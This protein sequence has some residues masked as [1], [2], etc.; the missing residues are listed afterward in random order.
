M[1]ANLLE[2]K[3]LLIQEQNK[4]T[5]QIS[6][7]PDIEQQYIN[8]LRD[9]EINSS[10]IDMLQ[11]RIL[12]F[13]IIEASTLSDINIIDRAYIHAQISPNPIYSLTLSLLIFGLIAVLISIY[14][15]IYVFSFN[16][17]SQLNEYVPNAK[18]LGVFP[19]FKSS[20][21]FEDIANSVVTSI[22]LRKEDNKASKIVVT[23]PLKAVGKTT[24]CN[25][26]AKQLVDHNKKVVVIDCDWRQG[27]MH[28]LYNKNRVDFE[29]LSENFD[30]EEFKIEENLYFLPRPKKVKR[31]S[32]GFFDSETF[33][34]IIEQLADKFDFVLI[35]S[36][37]S[38]SLSDS[39]VLSR[40][41]DF[42][43]GVCRHRV[44]KKYELRQFIDYFDSMGFENTYILY[45][46]YQ[47]P[48]GIYAY[49]D[50]YGYQYYKN[51]YYYER[52]D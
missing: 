50:Y 24:C 40:Y 13:S 32:I 8:L 14:R 48:S 5:N 31:S 26:L 41:A 30:V 51:E 12:E 47:K 44:T 39:F 23:G 1:F 42:V 28:K 34:G 17:P 22:L 38:L 18:L 25:L 15:Y 3:E 37:P 27:D 21:N 35:D 4:L 19:D 16:T 7:L 45:N 11:G 20:Q 43:I 2:K 10:L 6:E 29:K 33:E 46:G 36:P 49:Y 9:V 52:D